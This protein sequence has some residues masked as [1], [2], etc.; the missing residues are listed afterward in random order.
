MANSE[1]S[2]DDLERHSVYM[3]FYFPGKLGQEMEPALR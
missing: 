3:N 2:L 1:A